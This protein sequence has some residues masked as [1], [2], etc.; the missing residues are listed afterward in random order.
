MSRPAQPPRQL[1]LTL[2]VIAVL[3]TITLW[4]AHGIGFSMSEL[5]CNAAG[6]GRLLRESWPPDFAFL[7]RLLGPFLETLHIALIGTVVGAIIAIPVAVLAARP[8]SPNWLTWIVDRN[9]MNILRTLPDLFWA[10]LFATA[11]GFGPL[12]G[13]LALSVFSVAVISKLF[14]ESVESIDMHLP[15]AVRA[16]GGS[17]LQ[18]V[19]LGALPQVWPQYAAYVM[20]SFELNVR[21]SMVLGL[22]G[23]GGIGMILETQRANFEYERV[24]MIIVTVLVVVLLIEQVSASVR[25]RLA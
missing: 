12:A 15:E 8:V 18:M 4:S 1:G 19:G 22:V 5:V 13:A 23:A 3:A 14:S 25:R 6:G 21:G 9:F 10:M 7:P 17:W 24:T 20:Y 11:V 16:C 2:G